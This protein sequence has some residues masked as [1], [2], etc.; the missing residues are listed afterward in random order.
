MAHLEEFCGLI[1]LIRDDN[2][3]C[4][5][6]LLPRVLQLSREMVPFY[7]EVDKLE[8]VV[9]IIKHTV[10]AMEEEVNNAEKL[11]NNQNTVKKF[12]STLFTNNNKRKY[13]PRRLKYSE[14]K[15]YHTSDL[16]HTES[17]TTT[18]PE[19]AEN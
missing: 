10:M 11:L 19:D 13:T 12:L 7:A 4:F 14:P 9:S 16:F 3:H 1:D 2:T 18:L 15:I 8:R 6:H 17:T 5:E